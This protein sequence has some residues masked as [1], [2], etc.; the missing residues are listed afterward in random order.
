MAE[1][2]RRRTVLKKKSLREFVAARRF[3]EGSMVF[4]SPGS[5]WSRWQI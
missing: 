2:K 4:N 3:L 5:Q 1:M